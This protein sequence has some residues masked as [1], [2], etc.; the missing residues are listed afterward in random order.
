MS[1]SFFLLRFF[2]SILRFPTSYSFCLFVLSFSVCF[3]YHL[4][5][6]SFRFPA[7]LGGGSFSSVSVLRT[8]PQRCLR[9]CKYAYPPCV[10]SSWVLR[11]ASYSLLIFSSLRSLFRFDLDVV[12]LI[13]SCSCGYY[14]CCLL[15]FGLCCV[16][17]LH[18]KTP[19]FLP[20]DTQHTQCPCRFFFLERYKLCDHKTTTQ[21]YHVVMYQQCNDL[22][23]Y[24]IRQVRHTNA[25][26][27]DG[28]TEKKKMFRLV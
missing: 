4:I 16:C 6:F 7:L 3:L 19:V 12:C 5:R 23:L 14:L 15:G 22:P 18:I 8:P 21:R 20:V 24:W 13:L 27:P 10:L 9:A 11:L 26:N 1:L 17:V 25:S 28:L 2:L